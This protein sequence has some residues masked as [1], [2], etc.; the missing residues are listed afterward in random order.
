MFRPAHHAGH[1]ADVNAEDRKAIEEAERAGFDVSLIGHNLSLSCEQRML[2]HDSALVLMLALR[3][4]GEAKYGWL[5]RSSGL[6]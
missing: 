5:T 4:A 1:V 6:S 3:A 2:Q